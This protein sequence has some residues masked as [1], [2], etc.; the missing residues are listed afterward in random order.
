VSGPDH[1]RGG[2]QHIDDV[3]VGAGSAGSVLAARLS[4]CAD[5]RVLLLEA[6]ADPVEQDP[7]R[8]LGQS[9]L[10]GAN[11]D[12]TANV[13]AVPER[14]FPY[15]VGRVLGG[16][17]HVNGAI[18]LRGLPC[19][20]DGWAAAGN[21]DWSWRRVA[22]YV[23]GTVPVELPDGSPHSL[24]AALR[25]AALSYGL[26]ELADV[27]STPMPGVGRVP[28]MAR[29][30][31]HMSTVDTHL[32]AARA[33]PNLSVRTGAPVARV[34]LT[35]GRVVG[36]EVTTGQQIVHIPAT[37]VTLCAGAI[38]TPLILQRSGLGPADRLASL[39]IDV[40]ADLPG[41]GENLS[42]HAVVAMWFLPRD[43][44]SGDG[45][46]ATGPW[47][48]VMARVAT[49]PGPPDLALFLAAGVT[50]VKIPVIGHVLGDRPAAC[51]STMLLAPAARGSV[52]LRDSSPT[53]RPCIRLALPG[54]GDDVARLMRGVR[55][56]WSLLRSSPMADLVE[57]V[58]IWTDRMVADDGLL[59]SAITRFT[60]PMWHPAGTAR[61]GPADNNMSV[62]DEHCRVHTVSGL[63]VVDA[64]VL[65][66][67]P[68]ATPNLT[69][70]ML[71]ERAAEWMA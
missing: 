33:R 10:S 56:A 35:A 23:A 31:R 49:G 16:S 32:N 57:R 44:G 47:H 66:S 24:A 50:G 17:G 58:L 42:D 7:P 18:A 14:E 20:F 2:G 68:R 8:R 22:P 27:N 45:R 29:A 63:F 55:L 38:N 28:S 59:V 43:P 62:V 25:T 6:G 52:R 71:A 69:C 53:G 36:V 61:M 54:T 5:R 15:P 60:A 40:V 65:P 34:V 48:E 13:E 30:G 41:V 46:A 26:P 64:S 51:L 12:Y 4:E 37:R 11:W 19:D 21:P 1:E 70:V 9:I 39:G 67:L 3:I